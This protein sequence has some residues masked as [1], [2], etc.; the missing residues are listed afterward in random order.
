MTVSSF[1]KRSSHKEC[2]SKGLGL[3]SG[4][5]VSAKGQRKAVGQKVT[6]GKNAK[7]N[8]HKRLVLKTAS[9]KAP[10]ANNASPLV[11]G[12]LGAT[13]VNEKAL[14]YKAFQAA[15]GMKTKDLKESSFSNKRFHDKVGS[16]KD[17]LE[18]KLKV[19]DSLKA[20]KSALKRATS[21]VETPCKK[22]SF[23]SNLGDAVAA[24]FMPRTKPKLAEELSKSVTEKKASPKDLSS[25]KPHA[26]S[27]LKDYQLNQLLSK[28][29][30]AKDIR[31]LSRDDLP[32]LCSEVRSCL[33]DTVSKTAGH[34]ASGLGVV[35]LTVALHYVFDTPDDVLVWDV[36]HQAYPHKILTGHRDQFP[37]IRQHNG[38]HAFI[39]RNE[40]PYDLL[41][42]GHASTSIGSALGIAVAESAKPKN[43]RRKVVAII[44]DGA[45]SGGCA[46]EALNHAGT[47]KDVDLTV[48]LNDNE[49]SI[50]E[51]V[52]SMAQG[53]SHVISSPHYVKLIEGGKR[54]LTS[55]PKVRDLALR[56]QE[57]VKGMLMPGTL[58]EEFGFNYIGPVDGHD[59][60]R[61][62]T[63][64]QNVRD[65][66]GLK[67]LHVVTKKG[68][69][70]APAEKDPIC[71]HGVPAFNPEEGINVAPVGDDRS[72]S[73]AFGRWMCDKAAH[74]KKLMAITPAMRIGSGLV[75]FARK[76]PQQFFDVAIAEQHAMV[77]AS[78]LAA[79]GMRPVVNIYS[80]FMQR[81]Y[82]GLIHD[83]AVQ[84][85]P[86]TLCID[87]GGIVGPDGP[88]H[89]GSFDIA[90]TRAVPNLIIM[91]P[92]SRH[93]LYYMLNT[94]YEY[95]HPAVI[96]YPRSGGEAFEAEDAANSSLDQNIVLPIG[97]VECLNLAKFHQEFFKN[98]KDEE[99]KSLEYLM[100]FGTTP[101][102]PGVKC[103][104]YSSSENKDEAATEANADKSYVEA[105]I[106]EDGVHHEVKK[107]G[108]L[109]K[110]A[111]LCFGPMAHEA[112]ELAKAQ[113][114]TLI[115]MRF[116]KP[117]N[118]ELI[119][120]LAKTYDLLVTVEEGAKLGGIG[121]HISS[122]VA[123]DLKA[124]ARVMNIG[125][126]DK[127]MM[128][129][130]RKQILEEQG[131]SAS[132][133][134][135]AIYNRLT[136]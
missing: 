54:I 125:I 29:N 18:P 131:I 16:K 132:Q 42:T 123:S 26:S 67:F 98:S 124:K 128:E 57:H 116:I 135:D 70:Y 118:E 122:I 99:V 95:G 2:S 130:T 46:F 136:A 81:A 7:L 58:F 106:V 97:S 92:S 49:M 36:G 112:L 61:L 4:S 109:A 101:S 84:D 60:G 120:Y 55:L 133:I 15:E 75:E 110:V 50:S 52:G 73:A 32:Q 68:K 6:F 119:S 39:W 103:I 79:G 126:G 41:T 91:A 38:L 12:S 96:R 47:F 107:I 24:D 74:D 22:R 9:L 33:I 23:K 48:I 104:P 90:Y 85:L 10:D 59:I 1:N 80:S 114:V 31:E 44:G 3:K 115:N 20:P 87:R 5:I 37:T 93:D 51:N 56:A 117:V 8:K 113:D 77:F 19:K 53:L 102:L 86:I 66:P 28:I 62:V 108:E 127:F 64:L 105:K 14:S 76:Y 13:K 83:M 35:E 69:G 134:M 129:G 25:H 78:G 27:K 71:Y 63:I 17:H 30:D 100:G 34:L 121:E 43:A 72:Y 94:A 45:L 88:T 89:N 40:T 21:N 11:K 111:L 82:D 65:M